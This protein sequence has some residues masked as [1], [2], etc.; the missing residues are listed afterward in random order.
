[1]A[2]AAARSATP[3]EWPRNQG[4]LRSAKSATARE[5]AVDAWPL[6]GEHR[7]RFGVQHVRARVVVD[8]GEPPLALGDSASDD[9]GA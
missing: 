1:M 4:D 5:R 6:D 7:F 3:G 9:R 2:A 8:V